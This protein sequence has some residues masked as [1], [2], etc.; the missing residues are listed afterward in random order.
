MLNLYLEADYTRVAWRDLRIWLQPLSGP[1]LVAL[2]EWEA[3]GLIEIEGDLTKKTEDEICLHIHRH[4]ATVEDPED[5]H[6]NP[7]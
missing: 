4:I 5:E 6:G 7:A 3:K 1:L 2:R